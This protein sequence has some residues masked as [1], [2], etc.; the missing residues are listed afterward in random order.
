MSDEQT[1]A[2]ESVSTEAAPEAAAQ[3]TETLESIAAEF[4]PPVQQTTETTTERSAPS[5]ERIDASD[6][7]PDPISRSEDLK[8]YLSSQSKEVKDMRQ[9]LRQ[10]LETLNAQA[11]RAARAAE[12][13][14]IRTITSEIA[15]DIGD[16]TNPKLVEAALGLKYQED[17]NFAK[18]W[19]NRDSNPAAFK[20]AMS[21]VNQDIKNMFSRQV[22]PQVQENVRA[23]DA[24]IN[25]QSNKTKEPKPI[26][27]RFRENFDEE[28]QK[29]VSGSNI[30]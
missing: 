3:P 28:W 5:E 7:V 12:E 16:G 26:E 11:A 4:Q 1:T 6:D 10:T 2:S 15:Q 9:E 29:L 17:P 13:K 25:K 24:S 20:R 27:D 30:I 23:M 8:K 22:D 19:D 18:I 21:L 14:E